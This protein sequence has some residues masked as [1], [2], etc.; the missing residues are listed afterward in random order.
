M[1]TV[2]IP[3]EDAV[4]WLDAHGRWHNQHGPFEHK[5]IIDYFHKAIRWDADGYYLE[6]THEGGRTEK[7]YFP[8]EDTA[9]FVFDVQEVQPDVA[10]DHTLSNIRLILN[11]GISLPLPIENLRVENNQLYLL[12]NHQRVRF[13]AKALLKISRYLTFDPD[14]TVSKSQ[15]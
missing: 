12:W 5:R 10:S 14:G 7:V 6:Q 3:K 15:N 4:F 1:A 13:T 8:C 9:L 2:V 11:T